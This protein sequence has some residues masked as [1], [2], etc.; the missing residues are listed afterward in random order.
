MNSGTLGA[1]GA[2]PGRRL[3][4]LGF[5]VVVV[6]Y[7]AII[8]LGG[9]LAEH[10]ASISGDDGFRSVHNMLVTLWIP[11]GA[12]VCSAYAVVTALGWWRPVLHEDRPVNRWVWV[13][14]I[15]FLVGIAGAIDYRALADKG[16]GFTLVLLLSTR[17]S[18]GWG[19]EGM[20]RGIGVMVF[21]T[22]GLRGGA[23]RPV[24]EPGLRRRPPHQ[25][26]RAR[27]ATRSLRPSRS[28]SPGIF[29]YLMRRVSHGNVVNSV[30]H[31]IFDFSLISG[32][33][34][35]ANQVYLGLDLR[36][37]GLP[38]PGRRPPR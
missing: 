2:V 10:V 23:G 12:A 18:W 36:S 24:V 33:A 31:G 5:A 14:P 34:I 27:G 9:K 1:G 19:E 21:R 20:F 37:G 17:A 15:V 28:A 8:Q 22:H 13:V 3:S 4:Y 16:L 30:I 38:R 25:C 32:S 35:L 29:F 11:L 6:V 7:L 26:H